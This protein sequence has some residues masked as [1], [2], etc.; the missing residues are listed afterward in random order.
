[1]RCKQKCLIL[2][3]RSNKIVKTKYI[4]VEFSA[5]VFKY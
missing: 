5:V 2:I 3:S 4:L 1:M